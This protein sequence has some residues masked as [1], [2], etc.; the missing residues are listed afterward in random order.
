[1]EAGTMT[2]KVLR[3]MWHRIIH[4]TI[5]RYS[6]NSLKI[7]DRWHHGRW[8]HQSSTGYWRDG[9][10]Y[11]S[12]FTT[13][14]PS[15]RCYW[16][17]RLKRTGITYTRKYKSSHHWVITCIR[18]TKLSVLAEDRRL[19][20]NAG[21]APTTSQIWDSITLV[22]FRLQVNNK[23][24]FGLVAKSITSMSNFMKIWSALI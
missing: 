23:F 8:H 17:W 5:D 24:E 13:E 18:A 9:G 4:V 22:F 14:H 20:H 16:L 21:E 1:M 12:C 19:Y 7:T 11:T 15:N 2:S 3:R 10:V 6:M